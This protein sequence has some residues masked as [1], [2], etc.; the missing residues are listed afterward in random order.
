MPAI[1]QL[2]VIDSLLDRAEISRADTYGR[3]MSTQ[4][5][6]A[7]LVKDYYELA[8]EAQYL[9][10]IVKKMNGGLNGRSS[11]TKTSGGIPILNA[12]TDKEQRA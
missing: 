7:L 4:D 10:E 9:R 3:A 8:S 2:S 5:R 12:Q 1:A 6:L 11:P